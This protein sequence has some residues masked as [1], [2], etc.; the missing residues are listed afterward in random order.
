MLSKRSQ[1]AFIL[2]VVS[3]LWLPGA[4]WA[5]NPQ[6]QERK[7][8]TWLDDP[9]AALA[10]V[11]AGQVIVTYENGELTIKAK[12]APLVEILREVCA[13]IGAELDAPPQAREPIFVILGP[14]PPRVI[15]ASLFEG[16]QLNFAMRQAEDDPDAITRV[17]AFMKSKDSKTLRPV[18][19]E[20]VAQDQDKVA[21]N[22][23]SQ[24]QVGSTAASSTG[25]GQDAKQQMRD[26][27]AQAQAEAADPDAA[28]VLKLVEGQIDAMGDS[29][30]TDANSADTGLQPA[31][32]APQNPVGRPRHRRR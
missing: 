18:A 21:Q 25:S 30:A 10:E 31:A 4:S 2:A 17:V 28:A 32:A 24:G 22:K 5:Q 26:L 9:S 27:L 8:A 29:A 13:Q 14:A 1:F 20:R 16:S 12:N 7:I 15:L 6:G 11:P 19:V 3:L 23:V